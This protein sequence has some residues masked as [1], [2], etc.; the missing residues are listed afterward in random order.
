MIRC[1]SFS[2]TYQVCVSAVIA[3]L[4]RAL[5]ASTAAVDV[6]NMGMTVLEPPFWTWRMML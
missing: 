2:L 4:M 5:D 3:A 1:S 6:W